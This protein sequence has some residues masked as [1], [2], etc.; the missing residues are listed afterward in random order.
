MTMQSLS[1]TSFFLAPARKAGDRSLWRR[2][3]AAI[4]AGRARKADREIIR[5]LQRDQG[6]YRDEFRLELERRFLGQ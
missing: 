5:Y 4:E 6:G 1:F 3:A 2:L